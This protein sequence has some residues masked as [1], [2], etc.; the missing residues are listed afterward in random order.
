[1]RW[2]HFQGL[3]HF[4][5]N[6]R[7][8]TD[9]HR[10]IL[11]SW[12]HLRMSSSHLLTGFV[13]PHSLHPKIHLE[14]H[15]SGIK[16]CDLHAVIRTND[17]IFFDPYELE[18]LWKI[19]TRSFVPSGWSLEPPVPDLERPVKYGFRFTTGNDTTGAVGY[20]GIEN[21]LYM[22]IERNQTPR[23]DEAFV[24]QVPAHARYQQPNESG[25][26]EVTIAGKDAMTGEMAGDVDVR[27]IWACSSAQQDIGGC[28]FD[29]VSFALTVGKLIRRYQKSRRH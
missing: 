29:C 7:I 4:T 13:R 5:S 8:L 20:R 24:W 10:P 21:T 26:T 25:Y 6:C 15:G 11:I 22:R 1:M 27:A 14:V 16:D 28:S 2:D 18:D 23:K 9:E 19:N 3:V 17:K 12:P